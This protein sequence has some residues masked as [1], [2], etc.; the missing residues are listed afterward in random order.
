MLLKSK[1]Y[2]AME[3]ESKIAELFS[4]TATKGDISLLHTAIRTEIEKAKVEV[5]KWALGVLIAA[6]M[7]TAAVILLLPSAP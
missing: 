7:F 1:G 2:P 5:L 3:I 6:I 4:Q